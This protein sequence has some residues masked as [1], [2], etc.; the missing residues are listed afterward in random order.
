MIATRRE[1]KV[2][3]W[4]N[5]EWHVYHNVSGTACAQVHDSMVEVW[6]HGVLPIRQAVGR[7][8]KKHESNH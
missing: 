4:G 7:E 2:N 1:I 8:I 5:A 3:V 6:D